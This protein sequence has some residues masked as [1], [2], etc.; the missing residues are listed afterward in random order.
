MVANIAYGERADVAMPAIQTKIRELEGN[1][2]KQTAAVDVAASYSTIT[3][4]TCAA[5]GLHD[6]A[7]EECN[8]SEEER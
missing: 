7:Q 6:V 1:L 2:L 4:G 8:W 3:G 5:A